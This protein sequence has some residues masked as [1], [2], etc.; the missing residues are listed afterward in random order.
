L[1]PFFCLLV[2]GSSFSGTLIIV[3]VDVSYVVE[4]KVVAGSI[5]FGQKSSNGGEIQ[6]SLR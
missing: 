2:G 5:R 3:M 1:A 6:S 4:Q